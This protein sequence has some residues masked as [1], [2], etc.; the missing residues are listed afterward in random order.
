MTFKPL[1]ASAVNLKTLIYPVIASPKL[2]GIRCLITE[3]GPATRNLKPIPNEYVRQWLRITCPVGFDGELVLEDET[4]PFNAVSSAIMRRD[5]HPAFVYQVFD[6]FTHDG[7]FGK[8]LEA[9]S[10]LVEP[11][12]GEVKLVPHVYCWTEEQLL[13]TDADFVA[14]GYEGTMIRSPD[15]RYKQGRSTTKE[16]ILLKLKSFL[17]EEATVIGVEELMHNDNAAERDLLGRTERSTKKEGMV[18]AGTLGALRCRFADGAEFSVGTGFDA[19]TRASIWRSYLA[20][21][22]QPDRYPVGMSVKIKHQPPP[23]GRAYN[24]APRFPVFLGFRHGDD[25]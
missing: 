13:S 8:R 19:A 3:G 15:G 5:G 4:G 25:A 16:G 21:E 10:K 2:D 9:V 18:P 12:P 20:D 17:D 23:S 14:Q 11:L 6:L 7:G 24:A 1:L 22:G